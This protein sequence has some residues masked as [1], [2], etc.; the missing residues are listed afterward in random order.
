MKHSSAHTH[1]AHRRTR[2]SKKI[3]LPRFRRSLFW[4]VD[5]KDIDPKKH[6]R[7]IIER[8][9]EYGDDREVRWLAHHYS[10]AMI[11]DAMRKSRGVLSP[12]SK[13]LWQ[14]VFR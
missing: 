3:T 2:S 12:K 1:G 9:L 14:S 13:T 8:I 5:P 10:S 6:A 4:D 11:A 7:Y